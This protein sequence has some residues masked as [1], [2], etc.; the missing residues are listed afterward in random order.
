MDGRDGEEGGI[1]EGGKGE[2]P[3]TRLCGYAAGEI[4]VTFRYFDII[5]IDFDVKQVHHYGSLS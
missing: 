3:P 2:G 5:F 4:S 1:R